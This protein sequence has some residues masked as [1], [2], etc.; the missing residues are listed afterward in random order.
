MTEPPQHPGTPGEPPDAPEPQYRPSPGPG[1]DPYQ[2]GPTQQGPYQPGAYEQG[3]PQQGPYQQGPPQ[4]GPYQPGAYQPGA[5]QPSAYQ[6]GPYQQGPYQQGDFEQGGNRQPGRSSSGLRLAERIGPRLAHRPEPRFGVALAGVGVLLAI[7][8]VLVWGTDYLGSGPGG[9]TGG[10]PHPGNSGSGAHKLLGIA[11]SLVLV[12]AGYALAFLRRTGPLTNAGV[13]AS[14]LGIP[15]L[16]GFISYDTSGGGL[17]VSID[18]IAVVSMLVW[19]AS[20][21]FVR[22]AQGHVFYLG[23]TL[24]TLWLYLLDK[25][26]PN[27]FSVGLFL[28]SFTVRGTGNSGLGYGIRPPDYSTVAAVSLFLGLGYYLV[29]F[30]L[31]RTGRHGSGVA[32]VL[33]GFAATV[34]GL[35]AAAVNMPQVVEGALIIVLGILLGSYAARYHR[36]FTAWVWAYGVGVGVVVILVKIVPKNAAAAGILLIVIGALLVGLTPLIASALREPDETV[37]TGAVSHSNSAP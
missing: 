24:V 34:G 12:A 36:R 31:D 7:F 4:Q 18:A 11:L 30:L 6:Q 19:A 1:Q 21:L 3:P 10:S 22:G 16:V 37:P 32:L 2:Q 8:G 14:A 13:A 15:V 17:P 20:Y 27:V 29:A 33:G 25:I 35:A 23:A 5:Y 26:D 9:L 28:P